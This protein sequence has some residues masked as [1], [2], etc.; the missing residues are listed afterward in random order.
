MLHEL[1]GQV[2]VEP[3]W[4]DLHPSFDR[5]MELQPDAEG[6][7]DGQ[8]LLQ[9]ACGLAMFEINDESHAGSRRKSKGSLCY[10]KALAYFSD[11]LSNILCCVSDRH[12]YSRTGILSAVIDASQADYYRTGTFQVQRTL[13]QRHLNNLNI[14]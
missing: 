4:H 13:V 11:D 7:K 3:P 12:L 14:F 1:A 5:G 2:G 8:H 10:R 9:L 6:L